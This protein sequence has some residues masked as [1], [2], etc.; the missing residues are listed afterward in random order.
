MLGVREVRGSKPGNHSFAL[1]QFGGRKARNEN[2]LGLINSLQFKM[3]RL[4]FGVLA[5]MVSIWYIHG[6]FSELWSLFWA[7]H[8]LL[9]RCCLIFLALINFPGI[10]PNFPDICA[11]LFEN[12]FHLL[13][14]WKISFYYVFKIHTIILNSSTEF[15]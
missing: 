7:T 8:S 11:S 9:Y 3:M 1:P 15:S 4:A 6:F 12:K 10:F 2:V 5:R 13:I 14:N